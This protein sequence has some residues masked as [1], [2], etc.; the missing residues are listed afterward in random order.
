MFLH[1]ASF[2]FLKLIYF[3]FSLI[4]TLLGLST[5]TTWLGRGERHGSAGVLTNIQWCDLNCGRWFGSRLLLLFK[6]A[7]P[8]YLTFNVFNRFIQT[9]TF[10]FPFVT[11]EARRRM[12]CLWEEAGSVSMLQKMSI[13]TETKFEIR[14][15]LLP[16]QLS[17]VFKI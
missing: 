16:T 6:V 1:V 5:R 12:L 10:H 13:D 4:T 17:L 2:C 15:Y 9:A 7:T 3:F 14:H 11:T 8:F